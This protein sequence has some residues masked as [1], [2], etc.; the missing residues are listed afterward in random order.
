M[1]RY[2][3]LFITLMLFSV[4][5]LAMTAQDSTKID[6]QN[7]EAFVK[8]QALNTSGR[9]GLS[10][11]KRT[12]FIRTYSDYLNELFDASDA[13]PSG[14]KKEMTEEDYQRINEYSVEQSKKVAEIRSKYYGKFK[15]ILTQKQIYRLRQIEKNDMRRLK[16]VE[17]QHKNKDKYKKHQAKAKKNAKAKRDTEK[18]RPTTSKSK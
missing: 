16:S 5:T 10:S 3:R 14:R 4:S 15:S 7:R 6:R 2:L 1:Y 9:L 11:D 17:R 12:R 18:K 13:K 8:R